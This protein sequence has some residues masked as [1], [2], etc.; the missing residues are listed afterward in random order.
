MPEREPAALWESALEGGEQETGQLADKIV[1]LARSWAG[2]DPE[3]LREAAR[4][5]GTTPYLGEEARIVGGEG[6]A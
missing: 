5:L 1:A 4:I 2:D 6:A 3:R